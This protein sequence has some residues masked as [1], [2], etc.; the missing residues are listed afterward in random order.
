MIAGAIDFVDKLLCYDHAD[1]LTAK[2]AIEHP[3]FNP[4]VRAQPS[5]P[6]QMSS[7]GGVVPTQTKQEQTG[8][9][10]RK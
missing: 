3:Y 2:Q 9:K 1:R 7:R 10:K 4:I 8:S 6:S 5:T